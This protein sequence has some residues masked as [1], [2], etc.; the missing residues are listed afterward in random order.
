MILRILITAICSLMFLMIGVDKFFPYLEPP[1][2]LANTINPI[3]WKVFGV[4][5]LAA[6]IFIWK[7]NLRRPIASFFCIFMLVFTLVHL[8]NGTNDV[9]GALLMAAL[10]G[11]LVWNPT[12]I[13]NKKK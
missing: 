8:L 5:Q 10:L 7:A 6:G 2:S 9:G 11:L 3:L 13:R 12:L 1:C 4:L